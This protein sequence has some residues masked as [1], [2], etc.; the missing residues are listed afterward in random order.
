MAD[1]QAWGDV[2]LAR[3]ET[4]TSYHLSVVI[5]DALQ[6][7]TARRELHRG[8]FAVWSD[9]LRISRAWTKRYSDSERLAMPWLSTRGA[10]GS[11]RKNR[12]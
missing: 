4:P 9:C 8:I 10:K 6:G 3:K 7:I 5:D 1:P 11:W 2:V 12:A